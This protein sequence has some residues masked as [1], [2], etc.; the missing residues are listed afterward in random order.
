MVK[1]CCTLRAAASSGLPATIRVGISR[2]TSCLLYTS[3]GVELGGAVQN[4]IALAVGIAMGLDYGD[5]AKAA[6][7]TRGNAELAGGQNFPAAVG[8]GRTVFP[9]GA[10]PVSYT[11][12]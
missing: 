6:L 1:I 3:R 7:I 9:S 8:G 11:H 2:A 12:L 10:N 4:V 5:N